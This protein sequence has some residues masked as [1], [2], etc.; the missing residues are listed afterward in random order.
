MYSIDFQIENSV[1]K[2][3]IS[4]TIATGEEAA[5]KAREVI[6]TGLKVGIYRILLDERALDVNVEFHEIIAIATELENRGIP[7]YG[8]RM[9][10]LYPPEKKDFYKTFETIYQN[11]SFSYRLFDDFDQALD[12]L[13]A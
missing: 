2:A 11:R 1:L 9:A 13:R 8:G 6:D 5:A 4:G 7:S 12:W 10:C 3:M